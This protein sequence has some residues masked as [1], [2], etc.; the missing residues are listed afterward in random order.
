MMSS[1]THTGDAEEAAHGHW[2][3]ATDTP[4]ILLVALAAAAVWLTP[5]VFRGFDDNRLVS[6]QWT[7]ADASPLAL[8]PLVLACLALAYAIAHLNWPRRGSTAA[9]CA[10]AFAAAA[11]GWS[12]PQVIVDSARYVTQAQALAQGGV[13]HFL[14]EWGGAIPVWTDLPLVPLLYGLVFSAFG[15]PLLGVQLLTTLAF[16]GTVALTCSIGR[17]LWDDSVGLLAGALLLAMPFLLTQVPLMLVDVPAMFFL[18][19]TV[20]GSLRAGRS[21]G[22]WLALAAA[23]AAAA[24]LT[25]YSL[26]PMLSVVPLAMLAQAQPGAAVRARRIAAVAL[27]AALLAGVFLLWK[28]DV[29]SGQLALLRDYQAPGLLRWQESWVSTLL[30]QVHPFVT[31]A[32]GVGAA[33]ALWRRDPR[34]V[35]VAWLPLLALGFGVQRSRYLVPVLPMLALMAAYGLA[36]VPQPHTRR[37]IAAAAVVTALA[38]GLGAYLPFL[39]HTSAVNLKHAGEYL[40]TLAVPSAEVVTLAQPAAA[41]HPAVALPLLDLYT[42]TELVHR[43]EALMPPAGFERSALRFTWEFPLARAYQTATP[44]P[45]TVVLIAAERTPA[46]PAALVRRLEGL[47]RVRSFEATDGVF[48]F[49]TFVAVYRRAPPP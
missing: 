24:L 7:Y 25:K 4:S 47:Q 34:F 23:A 43:G 2:R 8:L 42:R 31:L 30:F 39:Q 12:A 40:D 33:V 37:F 18:A 36:A 29:V 15:D 28:F 21:G 38:I 35:L 32:A 17:R 20:Y 22:A 48:D 5:L 19:A 26:W 16:V 10:L 45:A 1:L 9:L 49:Q 13:G 11:V 41:I 3:D 44:D 27:G 14:A 46:L 6:W